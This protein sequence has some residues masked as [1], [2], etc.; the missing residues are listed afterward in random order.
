MPQNRPSG[1][2]ERRVRHAATGGPGLEDAGDRADGYNAD[3]AGADHAKRVRR[4]NAGT[5]VRVCWY[6]LTRP[7]LP[8]TECRKSV[9]RVPNTRPG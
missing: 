3:H 2:L 4:R 5:L 7:Q 9:L 6:R 1:R 8:A